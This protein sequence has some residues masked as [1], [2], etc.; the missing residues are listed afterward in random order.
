LAVG[1]SQAEEEKVRRT[2]HDFETMQTNR[3]TF[4]AHYEDVAS[5][6]LPSYR[7]T[8]YFGSTNYP[9]QKKTDLQVDAT[10]M[11]ALSRFAAICDSLLTP[12]NLTWHGLEA[13][14]DYVMKDRQTREWFQN[15]SRK[16]FK[17]RYA[18]S[19]NFVA[20]NQAVYQSL[21]AFGTGVQFIEPFYDIHRNRPG[22]RYR[23]IPLGEIYLRTNHQGLFDG[24]IRVLKR[25]A[26][27]FLQVEA[28]KAKAPEMVLKANETDSPQEFII[29][30]DVKPNTDYEVG[31]KD[32]KGKPYYSCY[33]SMEGKC[34]LEEGGYNSFPAAASR[35]QQ[36]PGEDYGRGPAMDVLPALK[37]LNAQK[38][39]F[40]KAG[41]RAA[42]PVLLSHD[43]G[44]LNLSLRPGALNKGGMS[45]DG[46]PLVG[47]LPVGQIQVS[48][49]MMQE[50]QKLINDVFL[51]SLFQIMTEKNDMTATEVIE[52]VNEKGILIAPTVGRQQ[53]E[54]LGP[55]IDRELDVLSSLGALDP[56]P[57]RLKEAGGNYNVVYTSPLAKAMRAGEAAGFMRT[58]EG[59]KELVNITGDQS[60]LD[61]FSFDR[62]IPEI[63][64]IQA[65]PITWMATQTEINQKRK[66]RA[67]AAAAQQ[68]IQAAPAA[69]AIMKAQAASQKAGIAPA[70]RN[71]APGPGQAQ[72]GI[73]SP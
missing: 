8:F 60:L 38:R 37:T 36:A 44:M 72:P 5:L 49:E 59:V 33:V 31:R 3:S 17:Y 4:N 69:A 48:L 7:G 45:P 55:M 29:L 28:W 10:G 42:D 25:T 24:Y 14:D 50:E 43:D 57:P 70:A 26:R 2:L 16:L 58:V 66:G 67:Q 61:P 22:L 41:H 9:G 23:S 64:D 35:Y 27:Q 52:R 15:T 73:P 30:Q 68:K 65:V 39:D 20:N 11:V 32:D 40:L 1:I 56:M 53:S 47:V 19:A 46:K 13:D 63:A 6:I 54:Y 34:I 71:L 12:R 62:A 21:G 51:V 18:P